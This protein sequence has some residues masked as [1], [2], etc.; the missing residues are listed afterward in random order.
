MPEGMPFALEAPAIAV[1][2]ALTI[3]LG[4]LGAAVAV[5]RVTRIEPITA[6]GGA[7]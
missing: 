6:L 1:A 2:S 5:L 7:R 3:L 4:L